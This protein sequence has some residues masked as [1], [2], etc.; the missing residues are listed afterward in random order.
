MVEGSNSHAFCMAKA[1]CDTNF[2]ADSKSNAPL[3]TKAENS[4]RECPATISGRKSSPNVLVKITECKKIA[5]CVTL[6]CFKSSAVPWNMISVIENPKMSFALLN[7]SF[8]RSDFSNN[9][10]PIPGN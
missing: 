1:L 3:A 6:V 8:A 10:F 7:K 5:G 2:N 9:S 4:P